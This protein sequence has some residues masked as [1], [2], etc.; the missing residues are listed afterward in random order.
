MLVTMLVAAVVALR[1]PVIHETFTPLPCPAHPQ[2]T[3]AMEGCEEQ[4][5]LRDDRKIDAEAAAIFRLLR[6]AARPAFVRGEHA[7]LDYRNDSCVAASSTYAGGTA[8]PL[9]YA[10]CIVAADA[11]HLKDLTALRRSLVTP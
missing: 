6:P 2:S 5:I 10:S 8:Q 11:E 3:I 9:E 4:A 7:W 1:P